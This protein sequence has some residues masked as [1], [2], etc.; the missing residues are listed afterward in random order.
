MAKTTINHNEAAEC[1]ATTTT[2]TQQPPPPTKNATK[3]TKH[4]L[5]PLYARGYA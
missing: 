5:D 1:Y 2:A 4:V 3:T